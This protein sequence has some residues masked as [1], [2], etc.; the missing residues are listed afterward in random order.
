MKVSQKDLQKGKKSIISVTKNLIKQLKLPITNST[1]SES[2]L[3]HPEYPALS[4][5]SDV[6]WDW[7]IENLPV[8]LPANRLSEIEYPVAAYLK[9]NGGQFALLTSFKNGQVTY[10]SDN[11]VSISQNITEFKKKWAGTLL[12]YTCSYPRTSLIFAYLI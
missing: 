2:L 9:E 10:L 4:A 7:N 11:G 8:N 5:L 12:L 6:L 1:I 3:T